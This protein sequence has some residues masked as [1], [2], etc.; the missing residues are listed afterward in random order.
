MEWGVAYYKTRKGKIPAEGFLDGLPTRVEARIDAVLEAVRA[1][2]PPKFSGGGFWE[3]MHGEM[4]GYYEIRVRAGNDLHRLFCILDN[5]DA[6]GLKERG[7]SAPQI[8]VLNGMTKPIGTRFS[9]ADYRKNVRVLG[10]D[11][12]KTLPRRIAE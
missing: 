2:P 12:Q 1:A 11:Y 8:V 7:F 10:E 5:A 9:D 3:A 4:G 6:K